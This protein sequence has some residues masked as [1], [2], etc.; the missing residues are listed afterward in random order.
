VIDEHVAALGTVVQV[1]ED[2]SQLAEPDLD[3]STTAARKLREAG[4]GLG[5][6]RRH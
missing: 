1:I 5:I 3:P 6:R 4:I 2:L